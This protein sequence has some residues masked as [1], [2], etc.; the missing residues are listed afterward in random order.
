MVAPS[1]PGSWNLTLTLGSSGRTPVNHLKYVCWAVAGQ[2]GKSGD[3]TCSNHEFLAT[4][5][6]RLGQLAASLRGDIFSRGSWLPRPSYGQGGGIKKRN[7]VSEP[8]GWLSD[9]DGTCSLWLLLTVTVTQPEPARAKHEAGCIILTWS[10][11]IAAAGLSLSPW[12]WQDSQDLCLPLRGQW[13]GRCSLA[14]ETQAGSLPTHLQSLQQC[15]RRVARAGG[16]RNAGV[17][18]TLC[19]LYSSVFWPYLAKFCLYTILF[20]LLLGQIRHIFA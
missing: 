3:C 15:S 7:W 10:V 14:C 4:G 2:P 18:L 6:L 8:F 1:G 19:V 17:I 12:R 11:T 16:P 5:S 20:V 9:S 13:P